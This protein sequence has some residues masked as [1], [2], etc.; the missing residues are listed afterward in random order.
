MVEARGEFEVTIAP[1][2]HRDRADGAV[3]GSAVVKK[4]FHGGLAASAAGGC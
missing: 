1:D 4:R 3:L 2:P